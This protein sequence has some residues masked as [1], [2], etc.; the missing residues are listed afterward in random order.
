MFGW[1]STDL[2][3]G[4]LPYTVLFRGGGGRDTSFGGIVPLTAGGSPRWIPYFE[5]ADCDAVVA[6]AQRRGGTVV[7]PAATAEGI[8]RMAHLADPHGAPFAV[9]TSEAPPSSGR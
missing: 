4:D 2:P 3:M 5:V 7:A 9:I 1:D 8:G 6:D